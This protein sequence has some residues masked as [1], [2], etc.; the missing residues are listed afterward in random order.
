MKTF[1]I[2]ADAEHEL[3]RAV[4]WYE[5]QREGLGSE[6]LS[7]FEAAARRVK[8]NPY[9]YAAE[10]EDGVRLCPIHRFPFALAYLDEQDRIWLVAVADQRRRPRY[11]ARRLPK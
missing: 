8:D 3:R 7:E 1:T 5:Q 6:F 2:H 4:G 11:W 10:D 9:L